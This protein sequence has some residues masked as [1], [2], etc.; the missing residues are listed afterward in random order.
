MPHREPVAIRDL[1]RAVDAIPL[2]VQ[3]RA[4]ARHIRQEIV[5]TLKSDIEMV[6]RNVARGVWQHPVIASLSADLRPLARQGQGHRTAIVQRRMVF[7]AQR[8]RGHRLLQSRLVQG[9][10]LNTP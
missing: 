7:N 4:I 5:P 3:E 1:V 9:F 6:P 8:Q 10:G 2:A